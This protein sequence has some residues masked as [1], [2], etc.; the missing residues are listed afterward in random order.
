MVIGTPTSLVR[1]YG[2][3]LRNREE[4]IRTLTQILGTRKG[5]LPLISVSC[6]SKT[7]GYDTVRLFLRRIPWCLRPRSVTTKG[8]G[9][10]LDVRGTGTLRCRGSLGVPGELKKKK[11]R[12]YCEEKSSDNV[13]ISL[14][15]ETR[16]NRDGS[17][18]TGDRGQ[19]NNKYRVE[20]TGEESL[21][22]GLVRDISQSVIYDFRNT[23]NDRDIVV[24]L[25]H[26]TYVVFIIFIRIDTRLF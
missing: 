14:L 5:L 15:T 20:F 17:V 12:N 21:R 23:R 9:G 13:L 18:E 24:Q 10:V 3:P 11:K 22:E 16:G 4:W 7:R 1:E 6:T 26:Q 25:R 8:W 19:K 2:Y